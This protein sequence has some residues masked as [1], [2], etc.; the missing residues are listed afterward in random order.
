MGLVEQTSA[1]RFF[2]GQ[3]GALCVRPAD[4]TFE[5]VASVIYPL[6]CESLHRAARHPKFFFAQRS[7][8]LHH[9]A[10]RGCRSLEV[11]G[12]FIPTCG[13]RI[14]DRFSG[15]FQLNFWATNLKALK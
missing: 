7:N 13:M 5:F 3:C 14:S 15:G 6:Q 8:I 4:F 9:F 11:E 2:A 10:C 12:L 1:M